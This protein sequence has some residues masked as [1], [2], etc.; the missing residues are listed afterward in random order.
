PA[1]LQEPRGPHQ[2]GRRSPHRGDAPVDVRLHR[3]HQPAE[4]DAERRGGLVETGDGRDLSLIE[5]GAN[6]GPRHGDLLPRRGGLSTSVPLLRSTPSELP[7]LKA[8]M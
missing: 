4:I 5:R 2:P 1:L 3:A 7:I 6:A 8:R